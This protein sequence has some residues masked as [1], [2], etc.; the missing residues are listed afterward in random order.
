MTGI[1]LTRR[2]SRR[3]IIRKGA[4][5]LTF[6]SAPAVLAMPARAASKTLRIL[7]W[8]NFVPAYETWFNETFVPEWG[9]QNDTDVIVDNVGLGDVGKVAA[10]EAAAG[11][12][13][14]MVLFLSPRPSLE[15]YVIDHRDVFEEC[16]LRFGNAYPFVVESCFNA[17]TERYHGFCESYAPTLVTYR[18]DIWDAVGTLPET[19]DDVRKAGRAVKLLHDTPVGI[20]FGLEHNAEHSQR[21]LMAAYG[22]SVQ[23]GNGRPALASAQTLEAL[24]FAKALYEETMRPEVLNWAPPSNNQALLAGSASLT[25]DTM[26]IIRAAESKHLPVEPNLALAL[27]PEGPTGRAGPAYA[28]NTYVIWKFA[29]NITGAKKFLVDSM[30]AFRDGLHKS[31]FQNMPSF[32]GSVPNLDEIIANSPGRAGRYDVLKDV[33]SSLTNLGYPG[34]SNAATDEVRSRHIVPEMFARVVTGRASAQEAMDLANTA[35]A[36]IFDKW[37]QAGKI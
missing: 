37:Q 11:Q 18:K 32:P 30:A 35:I 28:T 24:N 31:G 13:H 29:Q 8:K 15:D 19:W 22:S 2:P 10:A 25:I 33:P 23:D 1:D 26:S 9:R 5:Y 34:Y 6:A 21:S 12:G 20:S 7:R 17:R 16:E 14:D 27:L 3:N 4:A 36:P